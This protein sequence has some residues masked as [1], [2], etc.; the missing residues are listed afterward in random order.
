MVSPLNLNS[1]QF[2]STELKPQFNPQTQGVNNQK[3][4]LAPLAAVG[5][6]AANSWW[7][8]PLI[9][10][11]CTGLGAWAVKNIVNILR[12]QPQESLTAT[13]L[14]QQSQA[15]K[16]IQADSN[17]QKKA[18]DEIKAAVSAQITS[19]LQETQRAMRIFLL[20]SI[21]FELKNPS[22]T[23]KQRVQ[24]TDIKSRV[25]KIDNNDQNQQSTNKN[26]VNNTDPS[27]PEPEDENNNKFIVA[28]RLIMEKICARS[29]NW[30]GIDFNGMVC[31]IVLAKNKP[32]QMKLAKK[33]MD[34]AVK[35]GW[36][37]KSLVKSALDA[38]SK[39]I[40]F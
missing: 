16:K 28:L 17:F 32:E 22:L 1:T 8:N 12:N 40:R 30:E 13:Q 4:A 20:Q 26:P 31:D 19:N 6:Y 7:V 33:L 14:Q 27:G 39:G 34:Y 29:R 24:L 15:L 38:L 35:I 5:W 18:P 21:N 37:D 25:L 11:A 2:N 10:T 3:I 36:I 9:V 23:T